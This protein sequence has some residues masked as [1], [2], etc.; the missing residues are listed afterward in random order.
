MRRG[1]S[2][3]IAAIRLHCGSVEWLFADKM[4]DLHAAVEGWI[5]VCT[6]V[7][8]EASEEDV[9]DLFSDYGKVVNMHLNLDRR[10]G[11]VKV[12]HARARSYR[13]QLL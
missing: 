7:H 5:I 6:N 4:I 1:V 8:E 2:L 3:R 13:T 12:G 11:Y 9:L 10:T